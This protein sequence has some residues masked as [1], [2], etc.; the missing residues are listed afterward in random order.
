MKMASRLID[1]LSKKQIARAAR[2]FF[3]LA[4]NKFARAA[5]FLVFP[6]LL[7]CTT[8]TPFCKTKAACKR[9]QQLP[10]LLRQQC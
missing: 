7:F 8:T 1:L 3:S 10:A 6:L 5:R 9:A 2:F 4:K